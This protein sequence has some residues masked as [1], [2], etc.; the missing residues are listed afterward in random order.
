MLAKVLVECVTWNY[1]A[2]GRLSRLRG[3]VSADRVGPRRDIAG[4]N[5]AWAN[6]QDGSCRLNKFLCAGAV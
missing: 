1:S 3:S 6:A 2:R 4:S 5:A